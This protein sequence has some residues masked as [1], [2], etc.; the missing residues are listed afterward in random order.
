MMSLSYEEDIKLRDAQI[1]ELKSE[2]RAL[3]A[4]HKSCF[5][6]WRKTASNLH[7]EREK[8]AQLREF[9]EEIIKWSESYPKDIFPA[10]TPEQID[11]VCK[12]SGFR[13][14]QISAKVLRKF[15]GSWGKKA[16]RAIFHSLIQSKNINTPSS[17]HPET[18]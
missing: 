7:A 5:R 1:A 16:Q 13:I 6:K 4:E 9:A 12:Q 11:E 18:P 17:T 10:P 2:L 15:T 14:D 3:K 8:A